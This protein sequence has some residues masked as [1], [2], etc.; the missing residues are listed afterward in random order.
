MAPATRPIAV[1]FVLLFGLD[2]SFP[3]A[4]EAGRRRAAASTPARKLAVVGGNHSE[5]PCHLFSAKEIPGL[6]PC[7]ALKKNGLAADA[8]G[9]WE[10]GV[11]S[12]RRTGC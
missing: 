6:A 11:G 4:V 2:Q 12:V 8:A 3:S 10:W 5:P 7:K 1:P 9:C